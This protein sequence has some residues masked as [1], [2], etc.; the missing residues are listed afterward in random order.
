[1]NKVTIK[2]TD[3]ENDI[4]EWLVSVGVFQSRSDALRQALL[5]AAR[6]RKLSSAEIG[7]ALDSRERHRPRTTRAALASGLRAGGKPNSTGAVA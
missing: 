2:L 7:Q 4:L 6:H 1:M 5:E 3:A